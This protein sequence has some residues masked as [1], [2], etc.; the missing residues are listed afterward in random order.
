V[1]EILKLMNFSKTIEIAAPPERVWAVMSDVER[2]PE[3]T[4]S[5]T[6]VELL[7]GKS[8]ALGSRARIRQPKLLPAVWKVTEISGR[9]FTW[10]TGN[11]LVRVFGRHW[12][13]PASQGSRA[14]L[15]LEFGGLFGWL[16]GWLFRDLNNRYLNMEATGLKR[17]SEGGS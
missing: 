3:W 17:R 13:E 2:W 5:V 9:S 4:P 11:S 12:V 14:S 10:K 1:E 6:S 15:S 8:L 16:F 7:D